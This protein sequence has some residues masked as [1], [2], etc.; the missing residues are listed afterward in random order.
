ME[1]FNKLVSHR[2]KYI[3]LDGW[4]DTIAP[5]LLATVIG[6]SLGLEHLNDDT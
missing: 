6:T 1:H 2:N 3:L 4:I 5:K